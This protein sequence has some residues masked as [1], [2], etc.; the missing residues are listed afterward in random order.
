M[1]ALSWSRTIS[2]TD[3]DGTQPV[4]DAV[5]SDARSG[6][7]GDAV[8]VSSRFP[9]LAEFKALYGTDIREVHF[10]GEIDDLEAADMINR[11][12]RSDPEDGFRIVQLGCG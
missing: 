4:I 2:G 1:T 7:Q 6:A 3:G 11:I 12:S 8:V 5:I 10:F 9:S